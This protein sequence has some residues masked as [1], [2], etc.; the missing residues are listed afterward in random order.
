MLASV[1]LDRGNVIVVL[2]EYGIDVGRLFPTFQQTAN[3]RQTEAK[4]QKGLAA[5]YRV[6]H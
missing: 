4:T 5:L 2:G 6:T 3:I 1:M